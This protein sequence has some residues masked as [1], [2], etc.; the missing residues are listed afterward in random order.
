[1]FQLNGFALSNY[2]NKVKFVLLE[3]E[4]L[5]QENQVLP[6]AQDESLLASSPLGKMPFIRIQH[7]VLSESQAIIEYLASSYPTKAIY[8][9]DPFAAAKAREAI[10]FMELYL[11]WTARELY[12]QAFMGATAVSEDRMAR[13]SKKLLRAID[14]FKQLAKFSPYLLGNTFGIA[15]IAAFCHLPL[16]GLATKAVYG[17]DFLF[18]AGID[19]RAYVHRINARPAAQRVTNDRKACA[20]AMATLS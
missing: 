14:G 15:D 20:A 19:W 4:I 2:Y 6:S 16:V 5:F 11:D 17:R 7:G 1:M 12:P 18:E 8:P 3:H 10:I 9:T 13:V